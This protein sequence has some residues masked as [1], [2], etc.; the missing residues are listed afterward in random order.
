MSERHV[1]KIQIGDWSGDGHGDNVVVMASAAKPILDV[2]EAYFAAKGRF[3][4][5]C[6]ERYA[7]R[8]QDGTIPDA[9]IAALREAGCPLPESL[10]PDADGFSENIDPHGMAAVV[11]WFINQGD[12]ACD[13]RIE[14]SDETPSLAFYGSDTKGRHIGFIGYGLLGS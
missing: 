12:A 6:P 3:P 13:V 5:L 4:A 11:A 14:A 9:T 7:N 8:Y 1:F 10:Q 2:R